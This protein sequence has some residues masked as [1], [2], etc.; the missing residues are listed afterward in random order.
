MSLNDKDKENNC[1]YCYE[2][3]KKDGKEH[4]CSSQSLSDS[5]YT[6]SEIV[7]EQLNLLETFS[8]THIHLKC[9]EDLENWHLSAVNHLSQIFNQRL[10]DL[11]Q[12]FQNEIQ[13]NLIQYQQ[14]MIEQ[15]KNKIIPKLNQSNSDP[16]KIDKI[17]TIVNNIRSECDAIRDGSWINVQLPDIKNFSV[18]IRIAKMALAARLTDGE[19]DPLEN[20]SDDENK[21][22]ENNLKKKKKKENSKD[23]LEIFATNPEPLKSYFL[24][25]NSSTLALSSQFILIH[26]NKKLILFDLNKKIH[27][28]EWNDNDYGILVDICWMSSITVFLILTIHSVYFYDPIKNL[29]TYPIKIETIKPLDRSHVLASLS[30]FNRDLYI[31]YHKGIHIDQYR[32]DSSLEWT[33]QKRFSKNECS[34]IK[35]IGIRD[36]RCD[37]EHICLSIMQNDDLKWRLDLMSHDMVRVRR[38]VAMDSGENQHKFFSML[39]PLQ[40]QRWLFVNWFTNKLWIVDQQGK[41]RLVKETKIKNIRNISISP[42]SSI[43]A[44]RME[45]P[46][47]L[48]IYK[49]D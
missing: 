2:C 28:F 15:L 40:D 32:V 13:P 47:M 8:L 5:V 7:N 23:L 4:I 33:L 25:T 6:L 43:M 18:P 41:T 11:N 16:K 3:L 1:K 9:Q 10:N 44:I 42:D 30:S 34:E 35:D 26:D 22:E 38:G 31:N 37:N 45:K 27:E 29:S 17:Q 36:V 48:K 24:E 20:L 39:I 12:L 49:L 19:K 46:N 14:N 21:K